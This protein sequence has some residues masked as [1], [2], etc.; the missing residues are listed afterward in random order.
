MLRLESYDFKVVYRP[1]KANI[2][3]ALSRLN[4][5]RQLDKGEEYDMV[6]L[7]VEN[8]VPVALSPKEIGQASCDDEELIIVK[9][10]VRSGNWSQCTVP[11]YL[12]VKDLLCVYGELLLHGTRIVIPE[13][14]RGRVQKIAH[15]GHQV[16]VKTKNRLQSTFWWP[17]MDSDVEKS[18]IV[19]HGCQVVAGYG[20]AEPMSRVVPPSGPWED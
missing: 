2:D 19:C 20:S 13:V 17:K 3:D 12:H 8:S 6:W 9:S 11:L 16:V 18:C 14:L 1:R 5:C 15:E 7:I 4:S 10:C